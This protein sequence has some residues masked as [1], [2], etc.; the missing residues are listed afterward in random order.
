MVMPAAVSCKTVRRDNWLI[1]SPLMLT[2][3]LAYSRGP[4]EHALGAAWK[5]ADIW[6]AVAR[7]YRRTETVSLTANAAAALGAGKPS[8]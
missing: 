7:L 5:V 3:T 6:K 8:V 2:F 4:G 1:S